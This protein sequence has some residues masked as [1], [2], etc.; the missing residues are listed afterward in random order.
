MAWSA[1]F[2]PAVP[3]M[4]ALAVAPSLVAAGALLLAGFLA[5]LGLMTVVVRTLFGAR[6]SAALATVAI[7]WV[8][9]LGRVAPAVF[10]RTSPRS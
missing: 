10:T 3:L 9:L 4:L 2:L 7:S 6:P 1:A 5:F 8:S